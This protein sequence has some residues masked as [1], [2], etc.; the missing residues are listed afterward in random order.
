MKWIALSLLVVGGALAVNA[1]YPPGES[2]LPVYI[3]IGLMAF[4][5]GGV[6][7]AVLVFMAI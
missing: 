3:M 1:K 2:G 6:W 5:V 7:I 4:V